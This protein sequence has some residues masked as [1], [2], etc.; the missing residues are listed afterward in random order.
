MYLIAGNLCRSRAVAQVGNQASRLLI[1]PACEDVYHEALPL[2][3]CLRLRHLQWSL[4]QR[5][6]RSQLDRIRKLPPETSISLNTTKIS[7]L[8][9]HDMFS[10][11][12]FHLLF[13]STPTKLPLLFASLVNLTLKVVDSPNQLSET[14]HIAFLQPGIRHNDPYRHIIAETADQA[15]HC[16]YTT[17]ACSCGI[18]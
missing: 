3:D 13:V 11:P 15:R 6:G 14:K 10:L 4:F 9:L 8:T 17:S 16:P 12:S 7:V 5:P 2:S 1:M 18:A